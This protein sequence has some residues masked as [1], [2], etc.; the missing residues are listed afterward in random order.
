MKDGYTGKVLWESD[1]GSYMAR[2]LTPA[3]PQYPGTDF[4]VIEHKGGDLNEL[5]LYGCP[6]PE[7]WRYDIDGDHF[8]NRNDVE[9]LQM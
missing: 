9:A 2:E 6:V 5:A 8:C 4:L 1:L 7:H 3:A